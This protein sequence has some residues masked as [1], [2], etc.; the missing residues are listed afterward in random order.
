MFVLSACGGGGGGG[1][2]TGGPP[3]GAPSVSGDMLAYQA[4]RGWNY[5]G[6]AFGGQAVTFSVY[7]DPPSGGLDTFVLFGGFGTAPN[8]FTGSKLAQAQFQNNGG[9]YNATSY[10]LYNSNGSVYAQG[11]IPGSPTLVP[12]TLTQGASFTSYP[13]LTAVVQTVGTVPGANACPTPATG[14]TVAYSYAGQNYTVSYV[15]GC[16]IT[17]YTGNNH[18]VLTLV[19]VGTYQLGTQ[20]SR[21]METLTLF[22]TLSSAAHV[23]ATHQKWQPFAH[24]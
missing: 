24:N 18:E 2:A 22:D 5:Q 15:P 20:S 23:L 10:V 6:T 7:A 21:R 3:P 19:S 17:Q 14:A 8:A 13:G 1:G 11:A 4:N 16:G 12:G 9:G